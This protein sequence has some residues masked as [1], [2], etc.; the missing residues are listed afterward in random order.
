V[1]WAPGVL[2]ETY[3]GVLDIHGKFEGVDP[4]QKARENVDS[5]RD[6][7]P[8]AEVSE[9]DE[10]MAT[11]PK[12]LL[13]DPNDIHVLAAG[14]KCRASII[15][16]ENTRDFPV[17]VLEHFNIEVAT[18]DDFIANTVDLSLHKAVAA[19]RE[20]RGRFRKPEMDGEQL[21][22]LF[23]KRGFLQT[24]DILREHVMHL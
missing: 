20:M 19:L 5:I 12:G 1:R 18:A 2:E 22:L 8:E 13:P 4:E 17:D 21:L 23:E 14:V 9:F 3:Q 7:F 16:T 24:A 10:I 15:V 6:A 11:L